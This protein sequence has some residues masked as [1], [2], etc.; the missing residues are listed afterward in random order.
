MEHYSSF[1]DYTNFVVI[2]QL[3]R[4]HSVYQFQSMANR[5]RTNLSLRPPPT[6]TTS[7]SVDELLVSAEIILIGAF[8]LT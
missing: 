1:Y 6:H 7:V 3:H 4:V 2:T 8:Y 5:R